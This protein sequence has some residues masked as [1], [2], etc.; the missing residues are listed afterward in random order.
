MTKSEFFKE[1]DALVDKYVK[2]E[3]E[4]EPGLNLKKGD[5]LR[6]SDE[7]VVYLGEGE[8]EGTIIGA[9]LTE[10]QHYYKED[11]KLYGAS[12][13]P[14]PWEVYGNDVEREPSDE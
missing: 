6:Y 7:I 5:V 3:H 13:D 4:E 8:Q 10:R 12:V 9:S 2:T 11:A 1:L 14:A